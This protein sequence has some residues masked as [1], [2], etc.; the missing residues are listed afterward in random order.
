MVLPQLLVVTPDA[1][2]ASS[3]R[4]ALTELYRVVLPVVPSR[5]SC[6]QE[7]PLSADA[8]GDLLS[9]DA[10]HLAPAGVEAFVAGVNHPAVILLAPRGLRT[11]AIPAGVRGALSHLSDLHELRVA[12]AVVQS[13][14]RYVSPHFAAED[15][16]R[17]WQSATPPTDRQRQ[18]FELKQSGLANREI[19]VVLGVT[20]KATE[21]MVTEL[22]LALGLSSGEVFDWRNGRLH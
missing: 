5:L 21:A 8:R 7:L 17:Y 18:V 9:V 4:Q 15:Q 6:L 19:A 10:R 2:L 20:I 13:G 11:E 1:F 22:R 14:Q 12:L 16:L 3:I